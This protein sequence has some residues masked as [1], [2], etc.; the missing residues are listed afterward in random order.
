MVTVVTFLSGCPGA[1]GTDRKRR[2][3]SLTGEIVSILLSVWAWLQLNQA[4]LDS[5]PISTV[6]MSIPTSEWHRC[7]VMRQ[8]SNSLTTCW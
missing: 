3:Q 6:L 4:L 1:G 5:K 8:L 2:L 7:Q